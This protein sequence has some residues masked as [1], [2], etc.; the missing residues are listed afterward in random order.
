MRVLRRAAVAVAAGV[1]L[2]Q[3]PAAQSRVDLAPVTQRPSTFR[4]GVDLIQVDVHVVDKQG[5]PVHDLDVGDF[6]V[7]VDGKPRR[8][9]SLDLVVQDVSPEPAALQYDPP[10]SGAYATNTGP[11]PGR[12]FVLVIDQGNITKGGG[13][14]AMEAASRFLDRL[15]PADKVGLITIPAGPRV[16]F[17][18]DRKPIRDALSRILG[19]GG[20]TY[21]GW[22]KVSL[23]ESFSFVA[24]TRNEIWTIA[25]RED[26]D[27]RTRDEIDRC[28]RDME[29]EARQKVSALAAASPG[30][31][32]PPRRLSSSRWRWVRV[33]RPSSPVPRHFSPGRRPVTGAPRPR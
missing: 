20:N 8:I 7:S 21:Q 29:R 18:D 14:G 10:I 3:V 26:C 33:A 27:L 1:L 5:N 15:T 17:T 19:G 16:D 30:P 6:T 31:H 13:K 4:S 22:T 23:A 11:Q 2:T 28:V 12:L 32:S 9:T 25:K 24:G